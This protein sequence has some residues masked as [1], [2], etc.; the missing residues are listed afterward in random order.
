MEWKY[1]VGDLVVF[2]LQSP[3]WGNDLDNGK[4]GEIL[5]LVTISPDSLGYNV[6]FVGETREHIIWEGFLRQLTKLEKV[7]F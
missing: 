1:K 2:R 3:L 7:L 5:D 4:T 6:Q